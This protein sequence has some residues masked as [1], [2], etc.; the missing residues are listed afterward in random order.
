MVDS[1]RTAADDGDY[2]L[3][4]SREACRGVLQLTLRRASFARSLFERRLK[5][6]QGSRISAV[7]SLGHY[8]DCP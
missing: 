3:A 5:R 7:R 8:S 6:S 4:H 1:L 2:P